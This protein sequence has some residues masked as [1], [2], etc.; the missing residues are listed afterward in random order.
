MS[1]ILCKNIKV[2]YVLKHNNFVDGLDG[3]SICFNDNRVN[4]IF[5]EN[6]CGKTTLFNCI[7]GLLGYDGEITFDG[8]DA[9]S[10]DVVE[11]K[12]SY[13]PQSLNLLPKFTVFDNIALPLKNLKFKPQE[14]L[15]RVY[16]MLEKFQI[17]HLINCLPNQISIGQQQKV[18]IAKALISEPRIII[19]DEA[20]SNI[21]PV[22]RRFIQKIIKE[23]V[24]ETK[25]NVIYVTHDIPDA[26]F[27]GDYFF[28]INNREVLYESSKK[29][30]AIHK[31]EKLVVK[32]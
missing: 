28:V 29:K 3:L 16:P 26:Q 25:C 19:L 15:K 9:N 5:G 11:R 22:N 30:L 2:T 6:G 27:F 31:L 17:Q 8:V 24:K 23:Y 4:V 20:F 10:L 1:E 13:V 14:I 32:K 18:C 12:I 21:D 7:I